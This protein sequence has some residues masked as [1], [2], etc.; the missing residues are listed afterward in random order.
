MFKLRLLGN[1]KRNLRFFSIYFQNIKMVINKNVKHWKNPIPVFTELPCDGSDNYEVEGGEVV[2]INKDV[3]LDNVNTGDSENKV[4]LG[5]VYNSG[6][7][8]NDYVG[9][10]DLG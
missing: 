1:T 5:D 8:S 4:D 10:D 6:G 3:G 2:G 9:V 7:D